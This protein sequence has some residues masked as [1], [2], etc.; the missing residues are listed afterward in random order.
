MAGKE[1][2]RELTAL[3]TGVGAP[4]GVSIFKALRQSSL[5]PRIV[6]TDADPVSVGLFRADV[7]CVLPRVTKDEPGYLAALAALCRRERVDLV[8]FGSEVE[9]R[10]VAP[11]RRELEERTGARLVVND[12]PLV[13]RFMD[14]WGMFTAL[15]EKGLPVPDT[16]LGE[17]AAAV[18]LLV[19]RC[20]F[21][22]VLKP[23]HGSGS[24]DLHVVETARALDD[25][26]RRVPG[27]VVQEH[28]APDDEEYT[29]GCYRSPRTG[30]L[31][32]IAFR[33]SLAAGL[34]YKAEVVF[35]EEIAASCRRIVEAFPLFGPVNLQL[36][37]TTKGVRVFEINLRF[38]SSAVM[39]AHFGFNEAELCLRDLVLGEDVEA[40]AVRRGWALRYW[41]EV[42]VDEADCRTVRER[43]RIEGPVGS[44]AE[45]F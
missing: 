42:Y 26:L 13:E 5:R 33:R 36:R 32:Q 41:D 45:D 7:G 34:T 28:L 1:A 39:R 25:L 10:R 19:E 31:G 6:A 2:R 23:R 3:V 9:M 29:V 11:H 38:S 16:A 44:K 15:R 40:P 8:C 27:P 43:G 37:K 4:P 35:D 20:G 30:Y 24:R 21:P 18:R 12:A 14:K 22:L 17:D